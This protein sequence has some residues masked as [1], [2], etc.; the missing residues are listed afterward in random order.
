[1]SANTFSHLEMLR[2]AILMEEEGRNFY[3]NCADLAIGKVKEF[4]VNASG[5]EFLHK[6]KFSDMYNELLEK[7][8]EGSE[9][10]FDADVTVYL[11]DFIENSVFD[12]KEKPNEIVKDLKSAAEYALKAEKL[13]VQVYEK[14][15]ENTVNP[16]IKVILNGIIDEEKEHVEYF[17]KLLK[18]I[19]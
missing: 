5:Q 8:D 19:S 12:K 10:L 1:M 11:R 14:L 9:Y 18:D 15:F 2:I 7:N 16:E 13:T 4:F 3:T 6:V 17:S